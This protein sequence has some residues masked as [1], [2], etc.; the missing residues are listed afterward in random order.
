MI[1][2]SLLLLFICLVP[3]LYFSFPRI[4]IGFCPFN[5][6][7]PRRSF[8][9]LDL[10][11]SAYLFAEN[12]VSDDLKMGQTSSPVTFEEGVAG[13]SWNGHTQVLYDVYRFPTE[14][15]ALEFYRY[16]QY[17]SLENHDRN[18]QLATIN[19]ADEYSAACGKPINI[20]MENSACAMVAKINEYVFDLTVNGTDESSTALFNRLVN[21]INE[22]MEKRLNSG[23]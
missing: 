3:L 12:T 7:A 21:Y 17:M 15:Q 19:I 16:I 11:L 8:H 20:Y 22:D 1:I 14:K 10:S 13:A 4:F 18:D 23:R 9:V 2:L 5:L 6:C